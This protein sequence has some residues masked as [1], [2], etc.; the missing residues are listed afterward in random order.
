MQISR[1]IPLPTTPP[2]PVATI[3]NFDGQHIGH[4]A[5][6][7]AVVDKARAC[8]GTPM[9]LTFDP[10]PVKVLRPDLPLQLL[11]TLDRK[12]AWFESMGIAHVVLL[13]F[14]PTFAA[15]TPQEFIH[16]VLQKG[17]G[18]AAVVVGE[19]F[20]FGRGRSGRIDDLIRLGAQQGFSVHPLPPVI[21]DGEVVSSTRIRRLIRAGAMREASR[22]LGRP[23]SLE[24][25][26][27]HGDR[28]GDMLGCHTAN[29]RLAP[30]RVIPPDG[31]YAAKAS[32]KGKLYD[33]VAYIGTRPTFQEQ[34]RLLEVHCLDQVGEMYG[35]CLEVYFLERLRGDQCFPSAQELARQIA[36]D[37]EQA[38]QILAREHQQVSEDTLHAH[39]SR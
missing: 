27:M 19:H 18:V 9:V 14:T 2:F 13:D 31:V 26:V 22:C 5:L 39:R 15:L 28:R 36:V 24:G 8:S 6:L 34:E 16:A 37:I 7:K 33:A 10:H 29:L 3:G 17:L 25:I 23:Y 11:T 32:W 1:G 12:L 35:D 30:D 21:L 20:V 4:A 38:R